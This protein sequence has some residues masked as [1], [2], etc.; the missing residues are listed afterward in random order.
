MLA[1]M[2]ATVNYATLTDSNAKGYS[3]VGNNLISFSK[4]NIE[5]MYFTAMNS[6]SLSQR[7]GKSD[8]DDD[9]LKLMTD[10]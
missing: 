5:L 6:W 4:L 3:Y 9:D 1:R 8:D 7:T 2:C 10:F